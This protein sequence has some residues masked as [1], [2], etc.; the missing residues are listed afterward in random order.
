MYD[1]LADSF[2]LSVSLFHTE[3]CTMTYQSTPDNPPTCTRGDNVT[4]YQWG[5]DMI[6]KLSSIAIVTVCMFLTWLSL[7]R[8]EQQTRRYSL[9]TTK[10]VKLSVAQRLARQSYFY[11]GALYITYIPVI[12]ARLNEAFTGYVHYEM[13]Y[14]I[15]FLV[16]MQGFWNGTCSKC[17]PGEVSDACIPFEDSLTRTTLCPHNCSLC[18]SATSVPPVSQG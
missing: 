10:A 2:Y 7:Y 16:P 13:L 15:S 17:R 1:T 14:T 8:Q 5:F 18:L 9:G 6:P 3:G 12:V 4:L 11:V